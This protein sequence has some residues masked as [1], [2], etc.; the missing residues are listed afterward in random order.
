M[1]TIHKGNVRVRVGSLLLAA[2]AGA[3][4]AGW[5][6]RAEAQEGWSIDA[7]TCQPWVV[8]GAND[9]V[10]MSNDSTGL[11]ATNSSG[12]NTVWLF[13]PVWLPHRTVIDTMRLKTTFTAMDTSAKVEVAL[14]KHAAYS[15]GGSLTALTGT[16]EAKGDSTMVGRIKE[17]SF[18]AVT[19][20]NYKDSSTACDESVVG[21]VGTYYLLVKLSRGA[22]IAPRLYSIWLGDPPAASVDGTWIGGPVDCAAVLRAWESGEQVEGIACLPPRDERTLLGP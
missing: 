5:S 3:A 6:A 7:A 10:T 11:Y 18:T 14:Y 1:S 22:N 21:E 15:D 9:G 20:C 4:V 8:D 17:C 2:L 19:I 13:C 16:C 12:D